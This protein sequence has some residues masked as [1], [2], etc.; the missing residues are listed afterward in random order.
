MWSFYV[1][2]PG[3]QFPAR[4][5]GAADFGASKFGLSG[6][7]TLPG[8][9][10]DLMGRSLPVPL[11]ADPADVLRSYLSAARTAS[12]K[13]LAANAAVLIAPSRRAGDMSE[14]TCTDDASTRPP[15]AITLRSGV[16]RTRTRVRL[17]MRQRF[18]NAETSGTCQKCRSA[19]RNRVHRRRH[20]GRI[21]VLGR[22][23]GRILGYR[24]RDRPALGATTV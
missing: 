14:T 2:H 16:R 18:V 21:R 17:V 5:R 22:P 11:T 3:G 1:E 10:I 23:A 20:R 24:P 4:W 7:R 13:A 15:S 8:R 9:R 6:T 19:G 12:A